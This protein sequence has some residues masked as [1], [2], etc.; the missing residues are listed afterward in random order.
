[1]QFAI[2]DQNAAAIPF[3]AGAFYGTL[4]RTATDS[5]SHGGALQAS[6]DA[7]LFGFNN[8]F[9]AGISLDSS[10][11][12]FG[13]TSTLARVFPTL[14]VATDS[15]LAGS[16]SVIHANGVI[17]YAP[18]SLGATTTYY[19]FYAVD[20]LDLSDSL[21]LTAGLRINAADIVT[22]DRSGGAA[23]LNG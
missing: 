17:G 8:Y 12:G 15:T 9:T 4:D 22:R 14:L 7:A 20:A 5:T 11:I 19:G 3:T 21:T 16:G 1:N 6:S 18:V 10:G 2:L 13:S 23:E